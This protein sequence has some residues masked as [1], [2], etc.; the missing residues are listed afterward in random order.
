[1]EYDCTVSVGIC[2]FNQKDLCRDLVKGLLRY[3]PADIRIF[4]YDNKP[5]PPVHKALGNLVN[6][7][8]IEITLDE[9]NSGYIIPNNRMA[10]ACR[11]RYHIVSNDDVVVGPGWFERLEREFQ[12]PLM[13]CVGPEPMFGWV[14][15]E[16]GAQRPP[17][18]RKYEYIEGWWMMVPRHILDR[19]GLF[20]EANLRI[21]TFEDSHM[22]LQLQE[23]GWKIKVVP[24]VAIQHLESM[25]KKSMNM[26]TWGF[27][28][29]EWFGNRWKKYV[30]SP[31]RIFP[32][33][34]IVVRD[35]KITK[36]KL[37]ELRWR[38]PNSHITFEFEDGI[39]DEITNVA[40]KEFS[41]TV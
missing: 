8:R 25:T 21:A 32:K 7:S 9:T 28:N 35:E 14:D 18:G 40:N 38:F 29:K 1:M 6:D 33:H 41:M 5:N 17:A 4:I 15:S 11:S 27:E 31:N 10:M 26:L 34:T 36:K 3:G 23:Y 24:D 37:K 12:D 22:C 2:T 30:N 19:Y 16:Y 13:A 39:V 20:D